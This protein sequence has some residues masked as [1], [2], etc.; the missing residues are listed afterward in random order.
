[1]GIKNNNYCASNEEIKEILQQMI[2]DNDI[3]G[4]FDDRNRFVYFCSKE[5]NDLAHCVQN[6]DTTPMSVSNLL[7]EIERVSSSNSISVWC[8]CCS[9]HWL[10]SCVDWDALSMRNMCKFNSQNNNA[11][12]T[13]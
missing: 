4:V 6:Y 8:Y 7:H 1:M 13:E 10:L 11:W 2:N 9:M 5:L 3:F 12:K